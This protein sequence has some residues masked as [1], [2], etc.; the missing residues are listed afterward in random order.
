MVGIDSLRADISE[1]ELTMA[2]EQE[3]AS[4]SDAGVYLYESDRENRASASERVA[5][6][7]KFAKRKVVQRPGHKKPYVENSPQQE[8]PV[9]S[10]SEVE[11]D[12][13][14]SPSITDDEDELDEEWHGVSACVATLERN[15]D[16]EIQANRSQSDRTKWSFSH[17]RDIQPSVPRVTGKAKRA[18]KKFLTAL[19]GLND[20]NDIIDDLYDAVPG[21]PTIKLP[22]PPP[23]RVKAVP[24]MWHC[25]ACVARPVG[26]AEIRAQP[27][28]QQALQAEWDRLRA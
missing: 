3:D 21:M 23:H 17:A 20:A 14:P 10:D 18:H 11:T 28:A 24:R 2:G 5:A 9:P 6:S 26:K 7:L 13:G 1:C 22:D 15:L 27:K 4:S 16:I 8:T 12:I 25:N 19:E